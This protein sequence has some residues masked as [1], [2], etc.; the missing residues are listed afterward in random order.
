MKNIVA[1]SGSNSSKSINQQ[2]VHIAANMVQG[3]N[4]QIV[5]IRDYEA[6]IYG[7][8]EED[9]NDFPTSMVEFHKIIQ[10]ADGF[11][12]SS[13]EHN[14]SMP[15][16]LKNTIDWLSRMGG[17]VFND[18]PAVFLSTSPGPRGGASVL[19][20]LLAIMPYQGAN[21]VGGHSL[22]SFFDKV[23]EAEL[24]EGEDK[25]KIEALINELV[26]AI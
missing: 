19:A 13:P 3:A 25:S 8:D 12:V 1:F 6:V 21:V 2:L 9:S 14:G 11:I 16:A 20:H 23:Q 10:S 18:K 22:G 4:V 5:N 7:Q 24:V 17:K 15:A 26:T